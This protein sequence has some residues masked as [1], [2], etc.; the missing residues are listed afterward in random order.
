M[1]FGWHMRPKNRI[2]SLLMGHFSM[3]L[4]TLGTCAKEA[5]EGALS[6]GF[7]L[8]PSLPSLFL[9]NHDANCKKNGSGIFQIQVTWVWHVVRSK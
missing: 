3:R 2:D 8:L 7:S 1:P 4:A 5:Y 6:G 9:E